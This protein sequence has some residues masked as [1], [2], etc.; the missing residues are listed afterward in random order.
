[1]T[2]TWLQRIMQRTDTDVLS[3]DFGESCP[4]IHS[5][6]FRGCVVVACICGLW[7]FLT[8]TA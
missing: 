1:M 3:Y 5:W 8:V 6:W 7:F 2:R 4:T